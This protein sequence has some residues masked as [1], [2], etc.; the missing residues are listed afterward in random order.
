MLV[1]G[2]IALGTL[3]NAQVIKNKGT[4]TNNTGQTISATR[5]ENGKSGV[6]GT[7]VNAG[8]VSVTN[9]GGFF[10]YDSANSNGYGLVINFKNG[11]TAGTIDV[12]TGKYDNGNGL[13]N[14]DSLT[15]F[16]GII[17]VGTTLTNGAGGTFDTDSGEVQF[18]GGSQT[19]P[20]NVVN[21]TYGYLVSGGT[22]VKQLA[23]NIVVDQSLTANQNVDVN[24]K[25]LTL[26]NTV[27]GAGSIVASGVNSRVIYNASGGTQTVLPGT[28]YS[29]TLQNGGSKNASGDVTLG[30]GTLTTAASTTFDLSTHQLAT[31]AGTSVSNTGTIRTQGTVTFGAAHTIAGTF[32]YE[33]ATTSQTL[34]GAN[35]TNLTLQGGSGASGQKNF[36]AA[37]VG[38]AG[39]FTVSGANRDYTGSTVNYNG[40]SAQSVISGES[41]NN[42]TVSG[43]TDTSTANEKTA[44]GSLSIAG[45][46]SIAA[47]TALD[48]GSNSFS[49]LGSGSLAGT[50]KIRWAGSNSHVVG[51]A[52]TTEFYGGS[53]STVA[54]GTYGNIWFN[55]AGTKTISGAVIATA[56]NSASFGVTVSNNLTVTGS[57]TVTGMDLNNDGSLTNSGTIT[58]N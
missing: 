43:A 27:G 44:S 19:V 54:A 2:L 29:L 9:S 40:A 13:T 39:T 1:A 49:T 50:G 35:Y 56:G 52:G 41:Y 38:I 15:T 45:A 4:I 23:G 36:P 33:N 17:K 22:G 26:N 30:A 10:N 14:N 24:G 32:I 42:L 57:L 37:T 20:N 51:G 21:S 16:K 48:M 31:A 12:S 28:Y 58:V 7:L 5:F 55:G 11:A 25:D 8:T 3:A 6:G 18:V 46:L 34:G 47:N 53:A